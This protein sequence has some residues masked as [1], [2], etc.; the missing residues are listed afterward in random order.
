MKQ[1]RHSGY[2]DYYVW[3]NDKNAQIDGLSTLKQAQ[4]CGWAPSGHG[5]V[6]VTSDKNIKIADGETW[7]DVTTDG[8][9]CDEKTRI[10][11][12][13]YTADNPSQCIYNG[14][15]DWNYEEEMIS[16]TNTIYWSPD[17]KQL[18]FASFDVSE[19]ERLEYSV[20]PE[21]LKAA[22]PNEIDGTSFEQYPRL[23]LI[24]YAKAGG[25]I[26][27]TKLYIYD[28]A[29]DAKT[30]INAVD[31]A[32]SLKFE[33]GFGVDQE[34]RWFTRFAWSPDSKWFV[35][36]WSSRD[37]TQSKALACEVGKYDDCKPAGREDGGVKV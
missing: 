8:G 14:V 9:W 26:A 19:I 5:F 37:A 16:T 30:E 3:D 32:G 7:K 18:A 17:G 13:E 34:N 2:A 12:V 11:G 21:N 31:G 22:S 6:C 33:Q 20:Y 10:L 27:K 23:N 15:P 25:K 28:V 29:G 36:I 24:R 35:S 4:Y 1:W